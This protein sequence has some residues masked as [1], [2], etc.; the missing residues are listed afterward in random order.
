MR[1]IFNTLISKLLVYFAHQVNI[2]FAF[3]KKKKKI[4]GQEDQSS[5]KEMRDQSD[6]GFLGH[7]VC[8]VAKQ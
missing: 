3:F 5:K 7:K 2:D 8:L 1:S 4:F 6:F